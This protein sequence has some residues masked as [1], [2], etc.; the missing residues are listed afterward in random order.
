[1][2][3]LFEEL[4]G[5]YHQEGNYFLPDLS[6]PETAPVG[7]WGQ[8]RRHYLTTQHRPLYNALLLGGKLNDHLIAVDTQAEAMFFQLVKQ[9][10]EQEGI[11][12]QF[13]AENQMEWVGRMNN[14]RN[15]VEGIIYNGFIYTSP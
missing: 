13:K 15:Q 9:L 14:I 3:S 7:I 1:M 2:K 6:L 4:G 5:T 8:R 10:A 11:T 12:E